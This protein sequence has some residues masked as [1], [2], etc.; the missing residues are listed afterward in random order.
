MK[1]LENFLREN[2]KNSVA[3]IHMG[4]LKSKDVPACAGRWP[5]SGSKADLLHNGSAM[6]IYEYYEAGRADVMLQ[7]AGVRL[8]S[9]VADALRH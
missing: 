5:N 3:L 2:S 9:L 4:Q 8:S 1:S 7:P 6:N